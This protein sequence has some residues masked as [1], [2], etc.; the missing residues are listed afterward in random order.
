MTTDTDRLIHAYIEGDLTTEQAAQLSAWVEQSDTNAEHFV[1][2]CVQHYLLREQA[3][4]KDLAESAFSMEGRQAGDADDAE[5]LTSPGLLQHLSELGTQGQPSDE[6]P[7]IHIDSSTPLTRKAYSS[8]LSY[9]IKHTFTPKRVAILATAAALLL[10]VVLAIVLLVGGPDGTQEIAGTPEQPAAVDGQ[11]D[12]RPRV[13][14]TLTAERDAVWERQPV[15]DLRAGQRFKLTQGTA[16]ITTQRGAVAILE[17]PATVELLDNDNDNDN[18]NA[19]RLHAGKLVGICDTES[20]KGFTVFTDTAEV[21]DIGTVFGVERDAFG[22][23]MVGVLSGHVVLSYKASNDEARLLE[24]GDVA[25]VSA[26]GLAIAKPPADAI[27]RFHDWGRLLRPVTVS[28]DAVFVEN[29]P[30]ELHQDHELVRVYREPAGVLLHEDLGVSRTQTGPYRPSD[31]KERS[32]VTT[33][34]R[35]DSYFVHINRPSRPTNSI[36][37]TFTITFDQ[38]V[39]GLIVHTDLVIETNG[40]FGNPGMRY[41]KAGGIGLVSKSGFEPDAPQVDSIQWSD[42]R[43][44]LTVTLNVEDADQFRVLTL[45]PETTS[46][47]GTPE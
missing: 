26:Q 22:Q 41:L 27:E 25:A 42:N 10:G 12:A 34:T 29:M 19:I 6:L 43:K 39:V 31:P 24:A 28:G 15:P 46:A 17:A 9:V 7:L 13:V 35:V 4:G 3:V 20:S 30:A 44:T 38:P 36:S 37:R 5:G 18:D 40:R 16:E 21:T 1:R 23:T 32:T 47:P 14:A 2:A 45:S 11:I 33:G 8:A